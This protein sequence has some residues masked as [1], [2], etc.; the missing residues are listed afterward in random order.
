MDLG[1]PNFEIL[2][3][4]EQKTLEELHSLLAEEFV[5]RIR[6][7]EASPADLNA[8]RQFLRDNGIDATPNEANPLFNLAMTLP[9]NSEK[10]IE[11]KGL[12]VKE[13]EPL[14]FNEI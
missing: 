13:P 8:A 14:P 11:I 9:F 7:G 12:S 1:I 2:P 5:R 3:M 10:P 4:T 6:S